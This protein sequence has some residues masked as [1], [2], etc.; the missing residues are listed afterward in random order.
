[1]LWLRDQTPR[2]RAE[3]R[4]I[5]SLY[6]TASA[7]VMYDSDPERKSETSLLTSTL[8]PADPLLRPT[9]R[10]YPSARFAHRWTSRWRDGV[11]PLCPPHPLLTFPRRKV[12]R[13]QQT[14]G[15]D[16]VGP[17]SECIRVSRECEG[18]WER[19]REK[20]PSLSFISLLPLLHLPA[21]ESSWFS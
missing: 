8:L 3:I 21:R 13:T 6:C 7:R 18:D 12:R 15:R 1:M 9:P 5:V 17:G 16:G 19:E 4:P 11:R 2:S 14:R 20:A 10:S